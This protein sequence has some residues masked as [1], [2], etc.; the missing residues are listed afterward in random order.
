MSQLD[1]RVGDY[2]AAIVR[3]VE[4]LLADAANLNDEQQQHAAYLKLFAA[5]LL[6]IYNEHVSDYAELNINSRS[7][8]FDLR[9][10]LAGVGRVCELLLMVDN[11]GSLSESQLYLLQQIKE[12]QEFI[13]NTFVAWVNLGYET[14]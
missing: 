5:R 13:F 6:S 9:S 14:G 7:Y 10:P 2:A 1:P 8:A 12:A 4:L 11:L 3:D